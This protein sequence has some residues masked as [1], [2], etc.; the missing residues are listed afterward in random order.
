MVAQHLI[1]GRWKTT[2]KIQPTLSLGL[3]VQLVREG[4]EIWE[5]GRGKHVWHGVPK[6]FQQCTAEQAS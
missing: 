1:A 4:R 6:Y 3:V 2:V 5:P